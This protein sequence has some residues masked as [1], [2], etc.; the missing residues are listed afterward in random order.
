[1]FTHTLKT[2]GKKDLKLYT[3][4]INK[5]RLTWPKQ[6]LNL[7]SYFKVKSI[8]DL[9]CNY[10][11]LYKEIKIRKKKYN[12]FGYDLEPEF[13][14]IG[15]KKFPELKKKFKI[16][17]I[18][19]TELRK[20]DCSVISATLEHTDNPYR[21]LKNLVKSSK[22]L[23]IIRGYFGYKNEKARQILNVKHP[24]NHNQFSFEKINIFLK[25]K[26]FSSYFILDEATSFSNN[27]K[28]IN[29]NIKL[30]RKMYICLAIK[31]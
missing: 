6:V 3:N 25:K 23:I 8:N 1:M 24:C 22:K 13:L 30:K 9:G 21:V 20:C 17:N 15:L 12:Y 28:L 29:N 14:K 26:N 11:Q 5:I 7:I 2:H 16:C 18:E 10:F 31:N 27:Y 4:R 19:K